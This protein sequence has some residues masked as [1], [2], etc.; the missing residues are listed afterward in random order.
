MQRT[1]TPPRFTE[2]NKL[3]MYRLIRDQ[4]GCGKQTFITRV[5]EVLAQNRL[6]AEDLGFDSTLQLLEALGADVV[7]ITLFKGGR[8]YATVQVKEDWDKALAAPESK[9]PAKGNKPWKKKKGDKSIK[10]SCP[11]R[12]KREEVEAEGAPADKDEKPESAI[13][14]R[15]DALASASDAKSSPTP[16]STSPVAKSPNPKPVETQKEAIRDPRLRNANFSLE[17]TEAFEP[18]PSKDKARTD[19][20]TAQT[21]SAP[22]DAPASDDISEGAGKQPQTVETTGERAA[23]SPHI[24]LTVTYDPY[25]GKQGES[26]LVATPEELARRAAE[27]AAAKAARRAAQEATA[28]AARAAQ[29]ARE[30]RA[31]VIAAAIAKRAAQ[32]ETEAARDLAEAGARARA[33]A[34]AGMA[35]TE[36]A[37]RQDVAAR[38]EPERDSANAL[39][40]ATTAEQALDESSYKKVAS[41]SSPGIDAGETL[42]RDESPATDQGAHAL[43]VEAE[44]SSSAPAIPSDF[45]LDFRNEVFCPGPLLH[46]LTM[47]YPYGADVMG[48]VSEYC[49]IARERGSIEASR[50]KATFSIC[51]LQDG[52]RATANV[53]IR[54]RRDAGMGAAWGIDS[55]T[56]AKTD[57]TE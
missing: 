29:I 42:N 20:A 39:D 22:E 5:E 2:A 21:G 54:R 28:A 56:V 15:G 48:I 55:V 36:D 25:T 4:L 27:K 32:K 52:H 47:L 11:K 19:D 24:E 12:V 41:E 30:R 3:F 46:T 17:G 26:S 10:P 49:L 9:A 43:A 18:Q 50:S 38:E 16:G 31:A 35:A 57:G 1:C 53:V 33:E 7:K 44:S 14:S 37:V 51:Y 6:T 45:P 23:D 8:A 13:D 34:E 40:P